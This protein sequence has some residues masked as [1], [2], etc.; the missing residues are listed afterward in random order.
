MHK[1]EEEKEEDD[2]EQEGSLDSIAREE[3]Y[4]SRANKVDEWWVWFREKTRLTWKG[5]NGLAAHAYRRRGFEETLTQRNTVCRGLLDTRNLFCLI[6]LQNVVWKCGPFIV[7]HVV[8]VVVV[9]VV[10]E[11]QEKYN[12]QGYCLYRSSSNDHR[13]EGVHEYDCAIG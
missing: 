1:E 13:E 3:M 12:E 9:F 2:V 10:V 4:H 5:C 8:I 11:R 7:F 6:P